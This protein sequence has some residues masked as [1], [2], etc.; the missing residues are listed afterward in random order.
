MEVMPVTN[1]CL[2]RAYIPPQVYTGR[3][4]PMEGLHRGTI[5]PE[6]YN[7]YIPSEYVVE[8]VGCCVS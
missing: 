3:W 7:P 1:L 4:S 5:F 6:L 2:A 8:G